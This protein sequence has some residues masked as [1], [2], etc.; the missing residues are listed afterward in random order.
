MSIGESKTQSL[1]PIFWFIDS[2]RPKKHEV[3]ADRKF[4]K[5]QQIMF[6]PGLYIDKFLIPDIFYVYGLG[7]ASNLKDLTTYKMIRFFF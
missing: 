5:A 7:I 6:A 2:K 4:W 1:N 3:D